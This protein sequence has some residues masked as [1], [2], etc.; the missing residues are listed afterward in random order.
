MQQVNVV[1]H[2]GLIAVFLRGIGKWRGV[3][4]S[5]FHALPALKKR[6]P[7]IH[8]YSSHQWTGA[9]VHWPPA[10]FVDGKQCLTI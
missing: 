8:Y 2:D 5:L 7:I 3:P 10:E 9:G 1:P 6:R 4:F